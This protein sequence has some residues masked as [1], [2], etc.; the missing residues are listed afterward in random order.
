MTA[1]ASEYVLI[2]KTGALDGGGGGGGGGVTIEL[3]IIVVVIGVD[4][5]V[6]VMGVDIEVV[7]GVL[8]VDMVVM[9]NMLLL[10]IVLMLMLIIDDEAMLIPAVTTYCVAEELITGVAMPVLIPAIGQTESWHWHIQEGQGG[11]AP[12][13]PG[14]AW[15]LLFAD[16]GGGWARKVFAAG[17]LLIDVVVMGGAVRRPWKGFR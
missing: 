7:I 17:G 14:M 2:S 16:G 4:I 5:E 8:I 9:V 11:R 1:L 6:V 10:I 15:V 12:G 3:L 13:M